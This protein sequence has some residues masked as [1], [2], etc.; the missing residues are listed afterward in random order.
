M[1]FSCDPWELLAGASLVSKEG[2]K[3]KQSKGSIEGLEVSFAVVV[4][5]R[6][7]PR[8]CVRVC[9]NSGYGGGGGVVPTERRTH[10]RTKTSSVKIVE[11]ADND[12]DDD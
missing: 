8:V 4:G 2:V 7:R 6:V 3:S 11:E 9:G 5:R 10:T 12:D 1:L